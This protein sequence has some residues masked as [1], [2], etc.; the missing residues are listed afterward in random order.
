MRNATEKFSNCRKKNQSTC[1]RCERR[2]AR[3]KQTLQMD[4]RMSGRK[5]STNEHVRP[6]PSLKELA[7]CS[8]VV[9]CNELFTLVLP[10]P[11]QK[12]KR[13][14]QVEY[15]IDFTC[16]LLRVALIRVVT[17]KLLFSVR[18]TLYYYH[19]LWERM[20]SLVES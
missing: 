1:I 17:C 5:I 12:L 13:A 14:T 19:F 4:N 11:R 20:I 9:S 6:Y 2:R 7:S 3:I 18:A 8:Q 15:C 10:K 16:V